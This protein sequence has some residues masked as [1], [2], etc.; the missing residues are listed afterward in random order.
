[1]DK[2]NF[3]IK[4]DRIYETL[5]SFLMKEDLED[6]TKK[7]LLKL[8]SLLNQYTY[9]NQNQMKGTLSHLVIDSL[10]LNY[11]ICETIIK[12]DNSI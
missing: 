5:N 9:E 1:M 6:E 4:K 12:F 3:N 8:S 7:S 11:D 2:D 10:D